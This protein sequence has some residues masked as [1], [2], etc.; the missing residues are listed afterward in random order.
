MTPKSRKSGFNG[1]A[2]PALVVERKQRNS[3]EARAIRPHPSCAVQLNQ[4]ENG[5]DQPKA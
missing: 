2:L 4:C 3:H 1:K 5:E